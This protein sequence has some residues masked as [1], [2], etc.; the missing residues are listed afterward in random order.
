VSTRAQEFLPIAALDRGEIDN[1]VAL[2]LSAQ[3][4]K[5]I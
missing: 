1:R 3:A 2:T 4:L 5:V